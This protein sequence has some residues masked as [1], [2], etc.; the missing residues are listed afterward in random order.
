MYNVIRDCLWGNLQ[1]LVHGLNGFEFV[2][3]YLGGDNILAHELQ[4]NCSAEK[5][6]V[7]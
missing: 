1:P 6:N 2:V 7:E 4:V 3:G 5:D